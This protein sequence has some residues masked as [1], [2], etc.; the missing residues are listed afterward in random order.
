[1]DIETGIR[2]LPR[3]LPL[4]ILCLGLSGCAA[5]VSAGPAVTPDYVA[6]ASRIC[7]DTMGLSPANAPHGECVASLLQNVSALDGLPAPIE[8]ALPA[9]RTQASCAQFGLRPDSDAFAQCAADLDATMFET[10]RPTPG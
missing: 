6:T 7:R 2:A 4:T 3:I 9:G 1:M 8:G 10:T 5:H